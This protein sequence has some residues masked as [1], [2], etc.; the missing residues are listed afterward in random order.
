MRELA[1]W[2][3]NVLVCWVAGC[4]GTSG[5][6]ASPGRSG[7]GPGDRTVDG[8]R[9]AAV[10]IS[11]VSQFEPSSATYIV[12]SDGS[13]E[14]VS[15][16]QD[17]N[18]VGHAT[19]DPPLP[20]DV[21]ADLFGRVA[22][23]AAN[24]DLV[25][26]AR[27]YQPPPTAL[28]SDDVVV[29]F[30]DGSRRAA[31]TEEGARALLDATRPAQRVLFE[32]TRLPDG[33]QAEPAPDGWTQVSIEIPGTPVRELVRE[34]PKFSAAL[35][36]DGQWSCTTLLR[37]VSTEDGR[38]VFE[39]HTASGRVDPVLARDLLRA[40]LQSV[41]PSTGRFSPDRADARVRMFHLD[42]AWGTPA[43]GAEEAVLDAW[44][45]NASRLD[46]ACRPPESNAPPGEPASAAGSP[47]SG[48]APPPDGVRGMR[49]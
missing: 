14:L 28:T 41:H 25:D 9:L 45:A 7:G 21:V 29:I 3:T 1:V 33:S 17:Y 30:A 8:R 31:A 23:V 46:A 35:V 38:T 26:P 5:A 49:P 32:R 19:F 12:R 13:L 10:E 37:A 15:T 44:T 27:A 36:S 11:H 18:D 20:P 47:S 40:V 2:A 43:S 34:V 6:T 22:D 42:H 24:L 16:G 4:G 48:S 39:T